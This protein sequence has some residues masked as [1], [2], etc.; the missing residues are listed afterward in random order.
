VAKYLVLNGSK[1]LFS[2]KYMTFLP[3][4][5]ELENELLKEGKIDSY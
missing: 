2:S 3:T 1:Q 5:E 4:Q